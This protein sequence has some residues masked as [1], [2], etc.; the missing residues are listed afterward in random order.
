MGEHMK[1][2]SSMVIEEA[3]FGWARRALQAI[4]DKSEVIKI[5]QLIQGISLDSVRWTEVVHDLET[6]ATLPTIAI[7]TALRAA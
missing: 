6:S 1:K 7:L 4:I 5:E 3:I 2:A